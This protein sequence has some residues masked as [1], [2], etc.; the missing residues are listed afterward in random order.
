MFYNSA[1]AISRLLVLCLVNPEATA[2]S[3]A[4]AR[5]DARNL[6]LLPADKHT[7]IIACNTIQGKQEVLLFQSRSTSILLSLNSVLFAK[8]TS[9]P[10]Q[11]WCRRG[12]KEVAGLKKEE[13]Y[14]AWRKEV[15][16]AAWLSR[17]LM[18]FAQTYLFGIT[19]LE[20]RSKSGEILKA[21]WLDLKKINKIKQKKSSHT[22]RVTRCKPPKRKK[23]WL[24][25]LPNLM[26]FTTIEQMGTLQLAQWLL[27]M[28]N[29]LW[30]P[31]R[32]I[33]QVYWNGKSN[34]GLQ[35]PGPHE[36]QG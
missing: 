15:I 11:L 9:L 8:L 29:A 22:S 1:V 24:L 36:K 35:C 10:N 19:A 21:A 27:N 7:L 28:T 17:L 18:T 30:P 33:S 26:T 31:A 13:S 12:K 34:T 14:S 5:F 23:L 3:A 4:A 20:T 16:L 32:P 6:H 25:L 2:A